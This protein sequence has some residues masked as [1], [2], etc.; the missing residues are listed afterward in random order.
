MVGDQDV[1][2]SK[3]FCSARYQLLCSIRSGKIAGNGAAVV[4]AEFLD[5]LVGLLFRLLV[6]ELYSCTR[7]HEHP[8]HSRTD[9]PRAASDESHLAGEGETHMP[10]VSGFR[11]QLCKRE[12]SKEIKD[13]SSRYGWKLSFLRSARSNQDFWPQLPKLDD[14]RSVFNCRKSTRTSIPS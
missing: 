7:S 14:A 4:R 10:L 3:T 13:D 9:A 11:F 8:H 2:S 6:I 1:E 12:S 5:Q